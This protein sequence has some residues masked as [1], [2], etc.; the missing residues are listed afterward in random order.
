MQIDLLQS[1]DIGKI[2][3]AFSSL[4]WPGKDYPQ[5][6]SYLAEQTVGARIVLVA[7]SN[8]EFAGYLTVLWESAYA[9]FREAG[10]PEVQ[11]LN[12]LP[13][14]RRQGIAT[15]LM[16]LAEDHEGTRSAVVGIG[17]GLYPD[18]GAAQK[19]YVQRGYLPDGRG[20]AYQN[21]TVRPGETVRVDD[22]LV[23]MFTKSLL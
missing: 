4:G 12:V 11:D 7:R 18:Y 2:V 3:E 17:V 22:D 21:Q 15:A 13:S 23:L 20:I 19:L 9:P 1:D 8:G 10:I 16:D 5:Y 6:E 14:F